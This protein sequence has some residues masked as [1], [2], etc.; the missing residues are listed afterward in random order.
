ME[1]PPLSTA[2]SP[3]A[4]VTGASAGIGLSF[5]E[6]LAADGYPLLLV[7]RRLAPLR[8][9]AARL[10]GVHKVVQADLSDA[11]AVDQVARMFDT[12][13]VS[14]LINNAGGGCYGTFHRTACDRQR[15]L[16]MVNCGALTVLA[17]AFLR[18]AERGDSLV[19]L[20]SVLAFLPQPTSA[21][22]SASKAF[23]TALSESLWFENRPR[24]VYVM[25]L[26]PG[27]TRTEFRARAGG[28]DRAY[29]AAAHVPEDVVDV[30]RMHLRLRRHPTVVCGRLN[31]C[32]S[33]LPRIFT[34]RAVVKAMGAARSYETA[35]C[36]P[37]AA[38]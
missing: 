12:H 20:S 32:L 10:P 18:Q 17:H 14:L 22:Y 28:S 2:R 24:G 5:A 1:S 31:T 11:H 15:E 25:G 3:W 7:G 6:N 35:D 29:N 21:T 23:V 37:P 27:V 38:H 33:Q 26:H 9:L 13:R 34:R 36:P 4:M 19:N 30:A 16:V 8:Q